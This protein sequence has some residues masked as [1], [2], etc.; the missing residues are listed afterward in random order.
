MF[1]VDPN[2]DRDNDKNYFYQN[3]LELFSKELEKQGKHYKNSNPN[4]KNDYVGTIVVPI[5]IDTN[6]LYNK[7]NGSF[8]LIGFLCVDSKS[9]NAFTVQ[10]EAFNVGIMKSFADILYVLLSQYRHYFEKLKNNN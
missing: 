5:R 1:I 7:E 10:Q 8:D 4:W 6:N 2:R 9:K 3:D